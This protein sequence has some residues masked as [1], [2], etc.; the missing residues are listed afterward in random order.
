MSELVSVNRLDD[1]DA[2]VVAPRGDVDMACSP[3]L[4]V[5]LRSALDKPVPR[6]VVS[7]EDVTY[8]DSS[9]LATLVEA[10]RGAKSANKALVLYGLNDKV[11]AIFEIARLHQFFTI[12]GTLDEAVATA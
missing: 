7:F 2:M 1:R 10:M 8:M 12:A 6:V 4:R 5:A 3:E 11:R 9:G